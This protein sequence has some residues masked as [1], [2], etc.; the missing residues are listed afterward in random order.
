MKDMLGNQATILPEP[1]EEE[2]WKDLAEIGIPRYSVSSF[3]RLKGVRGEIIHPMTDKNGY[4]YFSVQIKE[5][6]KT[7]RKWKKVHRIVCEAFWGKCP[8]DEQ[9]TDHID[10]CRCNN[11]YK[12]LRWV[13]AKENRKNSIRSE[14]R[15]NSKT[16]PVMLYSN[17]T[18]EPIMRFESVDE[19]VEMLGISKT[20]L[21]ANLNGNRVPFRVGYF[22][23]IYDEKE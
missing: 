1:G 6:K 16:I 13:S 8:P 7:V 20:Q 18:D 19:V 11:Y 10:R 22:K 2:I 23:Y 15:N 12:N 14:I 5:N 4:L 17:K 3:G 9:I 21:Q